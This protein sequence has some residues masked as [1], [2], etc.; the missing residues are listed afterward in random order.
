MIQYRFKIGNQSDR[1]WLENDEQAIKCASLMNA[2]WYRDTA[3]F[4]IKHDDK[5][6]TFELEL[7]DI[8]EC[9]LNFK[10]IKIWE[11]YDEAF[12]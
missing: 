11:A 1:A 2:E 5:F 4:K 7:E 9:N 3:I 12:H 8:K 6:C 10:N